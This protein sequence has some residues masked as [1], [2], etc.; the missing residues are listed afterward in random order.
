MF[1]PYVTCAVAPVGPVPVAPV[2]PVGPVGPVAPVG[3]VHPE[4]LS[5]RDGFTK[6]RISAESENTMFQPHLQ[7][8]G[9]FPHTQHQLYL[10]IFSSVC[11][12]MRM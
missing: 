11:A 5:G 10:V 9:E 7:V 3:P 4:Q 12:Q 8:Q 6:L 2:G 1:F